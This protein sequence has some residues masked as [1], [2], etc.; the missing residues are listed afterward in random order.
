M[1]SEAARAPQTMN[2]EW[3]PV[4]PLAIP[5]VQI[6]EIKNVV[7]RSGVLTECYRSEWFE[8]SFHALHIV[9]MSLLAGGGSSWHCHR[10]QSDV[11]IPVLGQLRIG[12]YDDRSES[13]SYRCF[14]MLHVSVA[15]PVAVYVPPLVWHAVKNPTNESA[16]YV[17]ANDKPYSYEEPDDWILP[18]GSPGIPHSLD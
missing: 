13:S 7:V 2:A 15:R 5:G 11:V 18:I 9:H 1:Q 3:E 4:R 14:E 6:K 17:V 12:L 10:H 16:A 8:P